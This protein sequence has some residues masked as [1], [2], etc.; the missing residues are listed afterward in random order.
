LR[1]KHKDL[2][3]QK[4]NKLNILDYKIENKRSY[5]YCECDCGNKKW[6]RSDGIASQQTKS[7]GCLVGSPTHKMTNT[8][9]FS[10][11]RH[12]KDRCLNSNIDDYKSYG[13]RGI[14]I[15]DVWLN[16]FMVFYDWAIKSGYSEKLTLD[17]IDVNGNYEPSNCRWATRS[18]QNNNKRDNVLI[19]I[20]GETK[21]ITQWSKLKGI[22]RT[23][24]RR[25]LEKGLENDELIRPP[26]KA[27]KQ[28]G[29]KHITWIKTHMLWRVVIKRK[30]IGSYKTLDDAIKA[31]EE[32]L[33]N[34][35]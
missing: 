35:V 25:R 23:E 30:Y 19:E 10:I 2:I 4:I 14:K 32:Y 8:R 3:G 6:I 24:I 15:C 20:N 26:L 9:L 11:W 16:D 12:M 22:S 5:F 34:T 27:E 17:R 18:Q 21:T 7:C 33:Q 13:G 31:K 1:I 29:E 28:S